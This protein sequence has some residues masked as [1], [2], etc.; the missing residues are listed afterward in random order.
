MIPWI[1][2]RL[3]ALSL[4][5]AG[6][7]GWFARLDL[8]IARKTFSTSERRQ[9]YEEL[10]FMLD[11]QILL[12]D[13][14]TLLRQAAHQK[15]KTRSSLMYCLNDIHRALT[16]GKS[17]EEGLSGWV[18][19]GEVT[20]IM[21]G[22]L[23]G[24]LSDA[25]KR[26]LE[27]L[28]QVGKIKS[29]IAGSMIYPLFLS[30]GTVGAMF[31]LNDRY[32]P[33]ILA[34]LP[35]EKLTGSIAVFVG[36]TEFVVSNLPWLLAGVVVLGIAIRWSLPN[37]TGKWR[38]RVL[39]RL[40]PWRLYKDAEG[41]T[42]LLNYAALMHPKI[43]METAL[44]LLCVYAS[45]WLFERLDAARR[46]LSTGGNL[47]KALM[48]TGFDFPSRDAAVRLSLLSGG[49]HA[50]GI[51][52]SFAQLWQERTLAKISRTCAAVNFSF[53]LINAG[54]IVLQILA[55]VQ[56]NALISTLH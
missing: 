24:D 3:K 1:T 11:H 48:L 17:L 39:D 52:K 46:K 44:R 12:N 37:V 26:T 20:L 7:S 8:W 16:G 56:L 40:F 55:S 15:G 5:D 10:A 4:P 23:T 35:R 33:T 54:Y 21:S 30:S 43:Q 47:G 6:P 36:L 13:A 19:R 32:I 53:L 38:A 25:L 31:F 45:P 41:A 51:I 18:P 28:G 49:D 50:Q 9:L 14:I 2:A 27:N 34:L 22:M 29:R 42:F